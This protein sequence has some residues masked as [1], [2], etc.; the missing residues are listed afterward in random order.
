MDGSC[1]E[2]HKSCEA[3]IHQTAITSWIPSGALLSAAR[4]VFTDR[5][6]RVS[7]PYRTSGLSSVGLG[8]ISPGIGPAGKDATRKACLNLDRA[9]P[10]SSSI[11]PRL[12]RQLR[13]ESPSIKAAQ[14]L[15]SYT[16]PKEPQVASTPT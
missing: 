2:N 10:L 16:F 5:S 11:T 12:D 1:R 15:M 3:L 4:R 8:N 6:Q 13:P 9:E 14:A 7:Q